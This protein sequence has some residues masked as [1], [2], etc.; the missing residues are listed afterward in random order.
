MRICIIRHGVTDWNKK[1]KLQGRENIPLNEEGIKQIKGTI[2]YLKKHKWDE[3]I[4]SP[5]SR[6]KQSAEI[7]A[8]NIGLKKIHEEENFIERDY[9]EASGMTIEERKK[10]FPDGKYPGMENFDEL[11]QRLVDS[12]IKYKE[13]YY[14]K[15]LIIISHSAAIKS[16]LSYLSNN[17]IEPG[18]TILKNACITLLKYE[19]NKFDIVF[20][21]KEAIEL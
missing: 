9:G 21:N 18:K 14:G 15:N 2:S 8:E 10:S 20:Y 3:I 6:A 1:G 16:L 11:Q 5:L 12:L 7:I 13:L 19:E 17:E 4:T